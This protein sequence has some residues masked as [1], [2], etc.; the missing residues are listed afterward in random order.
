MYSNSRVSQKALRDIYL[1]GFEIVIREASPAAVMSSYNLL[2]GIHTSQRRDLM[3]TILRD[4]MGFKGIVMSDWVTAGLGS[5]KNKY[6]YANAA[7]SIKAGNDLM[8][9]GGQTDHNNIMN[10][11]KQADGITRE[12]LERSAA[13]VIGFARKLKQDHGKD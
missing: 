3:E 10:S 12:D 13:R 9:P 4:E 6:P 11:L 8:M 1:K 2:N 7:D 5:D